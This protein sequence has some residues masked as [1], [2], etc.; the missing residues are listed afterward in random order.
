VVQHHEVNSVSGSG[1]GGGPGGFGSTGGGGF[2]EDDDYDDDSSDPA[3]DFREG[4]FC[5]IHTFS[6][7]LKTLILQTPYI[8]STKKRLCQNLCHWH[9][10]MSATF[11]SPGE[12][13]LATL[14]L[15]SQNPCLLI[16]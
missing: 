5:A 15:P 3:D 6:A 10:M 14:T 2:G 13:T 4:D 8:Y 9:N 11:I 7:I 1:G 12:R 16:L